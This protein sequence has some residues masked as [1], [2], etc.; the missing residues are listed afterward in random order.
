MNPVSDAELAERL[1][2]SPAV[3]TKWRLRLRK[4]GLLGWLVSPGKG[5]AFSIAA[6]NHS[7][8]GGEEKPA[9]QATEKQPASGPATTLWQVIEERSIALT[10]KVT[11]DLTTAEAAQLVEVLSRGSEIIGE[12]RTKEC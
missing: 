5:R 7:F 9:S 11:Q 10:G 8:T 2:V 1:E 12:T 3:I 4:I 6:I